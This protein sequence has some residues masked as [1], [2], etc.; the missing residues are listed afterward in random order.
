MGKACK[1]SGKLPDDPNGGL[2]TGKL[3]MQLG[4][5]SGKGSGR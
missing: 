3:L 2:E 5:L 4:N 1:D